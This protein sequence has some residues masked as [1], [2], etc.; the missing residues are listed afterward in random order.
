MSHPRTRS[1]R[2]GVS[3]GR[4]RERP[5]QRSASI[6]PPRQLS[7][8]SIPPEIRAMQSGRIAKLFPAER[9]GIIETPD[10][11]EAY[12][13]S[14]CVVGE[15]FDALRVGEQVR[16]SSEEAEQGMRA[17]RVQRLGEDRRRS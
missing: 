7:I 16:F 17:T 4:P 3:P 1:T 9:F 6:A 11:H 5:E 8:V 12:F 14:D 13:S 10:G 2:R 15:G